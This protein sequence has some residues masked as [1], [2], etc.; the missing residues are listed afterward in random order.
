MLLLHVTTLALS[1][2]TTLP[3]SRSLRAAFPSNLGV[4]FQMSSDKVSRT[5]KLISARSKSGYYNGNPDILEGSGSI[6]QDEIGI[7]WVICFKKTLETAAQDDLLYMMK[8]GRK[9]ASSAIPSSYYEHSAESGAYAMAMDCGNLYDC[10][11][12]NFTVRAFHGQNLIIYGDNSQTHSTTSVT[13][14]GRR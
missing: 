1:L 2:A 7:V 11:H 10:H 6:E 5:H 8:S 13:E 12:S 9:S 14:T 3:C 4:P